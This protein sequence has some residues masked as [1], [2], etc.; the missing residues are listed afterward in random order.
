MSA[1]EIASWQLL[2]RVIGEDMQ[3]RRICHVAHGGSAIA[4]PQKGATWRMKESDP[5]SEVQGDSISRKKHII[6]LAPLRL[7]WLLQGLHRKGLSRAKR[8]DRQPA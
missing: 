6:V 8:S 3:S 7:M 1:A 4:H 2:T 5:S